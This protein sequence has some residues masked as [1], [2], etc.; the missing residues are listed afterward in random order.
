MAKG[1]SLIKASKPKKERRDPLFMDE[2]YIGEE[3]VWDTE[4]ALTFDD[5]TF[6]HY[7]RQSFRYYNYFFSVKDMKK[8][9]VAWVKANMHLTKPQ[10]DA[11]IASNPD[12]TPMPLCGIVRAVGKGMPLREKHRTY[13]IDTVSRIVANATPAVAITAAA[14]EKK[15]AAPTIQDRLAEKTSEVIG[16]I[17]GQVDLAFA[18]KPLTMKVYE[19][20]TVKSF[21]Q[22]QV[23]KVRAKF[24]AQ[25]EELAAA[26]GGADEQL[27]EGYSFL[28]K[29]G[30][31]RV[32]DF[33]AALLAD[34]DSYTAVKR[35]TKKVRLAK[36][37]C[38]DKI[39]ARVKY[40][41]ESKEL[42]IVSISPTAIV[43]ASELWMYDTKYRKLLHYVADAHTG[44]LGIKGSAIIGYD[45][46]KSCGKSLRK[47]EDTLREFGKAGKVA[48]RTFM[49]TVRTVSVKLNGR[50]NENH[51]LLK[52]G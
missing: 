17:E 44:T 25:A 13:I 48:L 2:Q 32:M 4:R 1:K 27:K 29:A 49:D 50:I 40:M 52:V 37:Q 51:L 3:P 21:A 31:K 5:V 15:P 43:G 46:N 39:V 6:D 18:G 20:L 24:Q 34:L 28:N 36:P 8:H 30:A 47:P 9:V 33:Y 45:E 14:V 19:F 16:E 41:K 42:K 7:L 11:Y 23:G 10:L 38:K 22:A 12:Q 26:L 35:A